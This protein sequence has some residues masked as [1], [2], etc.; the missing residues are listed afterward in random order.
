MFHRHAWNLRATGG[1]F[2]LILVNR[3]KAI[4]RINSPHPMSA[5]GQKQTC[6]MHQAMS[7]LPPI[8]TAKADM[9]SANGHLCFAPECGQCSPGLT[10][11][12]KRIAKSKLE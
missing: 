1:E 2:A 8:A 9:Y 10:N 6:A 7:A 11:Q 5:L 4:V 3:K 12:E